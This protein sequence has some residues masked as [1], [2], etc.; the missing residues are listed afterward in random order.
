MATAPTAR[1]YVTASARLK[2]RLDTWPK[3]TAARPADRRAA[4]R[5]W[6]VCAHR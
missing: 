5:R 4:A 2:Q 6:R 1:R 3:S